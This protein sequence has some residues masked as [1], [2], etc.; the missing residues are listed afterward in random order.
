MKFRAPSMVE[1]HAFLG[2]CRAGTIR[3]AAEQL[4]VSQAAVSRAVARLEGRLEA[5]YRD[6]L[7]LAT[8]ADELIVARWLAA[9]TAGDLGGD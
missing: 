9:R 5:L 2:V 6:D 8:L 1:L 3:R 4:C 7:D